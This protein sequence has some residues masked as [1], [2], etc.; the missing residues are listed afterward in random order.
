[1]PVLDAASVGD[2]PL[3]TSGEKISAT[4]NR[5]IYAPRRRPCTMRAGQRRTDTMRSGRLLPRWR[6]LGIPSPPG[7]C[8]RKGTPALP[9]GHRAC[10]VPAAPGDGGW[11]VGK[12]SFR[13]AIGTI[14]LRRIRS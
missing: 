2:T 8:L 14:Y 13:Y 3:P 5:L 11:C 10:R 4:A 12:P 6:I 1:M 7:A 9:I